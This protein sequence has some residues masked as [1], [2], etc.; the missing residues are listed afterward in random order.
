MECDRNFHGSRPN[1]SGLTYQDDDLEEVMVRANEPSVLNML[2]KDQEHSLIDPTIVG[3]L[4]KQHNELMEESEDDDDHDDTMMQCYSDDEDHTAHS[5][6]VFG[7][8]DE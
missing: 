5:I 3:K 2:H 8:D 7:D 1:G 4:V 6:P